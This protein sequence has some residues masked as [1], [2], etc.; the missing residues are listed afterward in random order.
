M[1]LIAIS[2]NLVLCLLLVCALAYGVR[3]DR[4]LKAIRDGQ[5]AF[6][7]AV[8]DLN[9]ATEKA[10]AGLAE[11][12]ETTDESTDLLGGRI[13]RAREVAERLERVVNRAEAIPAAAPAAAIETLTPEMGPEGGLS[14]LLARLKA[15][16]GQAPVTSAPVIEDRPQRSFRPA[17]DEDLFD[18]AGAFA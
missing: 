6:G 11:L 4:R 12:R 13:A 9:V 17:I 8:A 3:L 1:S 16:E 2:L 5:L 7:K 10:R 15:A 18:D 14:A